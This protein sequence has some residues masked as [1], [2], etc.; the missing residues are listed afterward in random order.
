MS[1]QQ[2]E[3]QLGS[4]TFMIYEDAMNN[5]VMPKLFDLMEKEG[6]SVQEMKSAIE[7][8]CGWDVADWFEEWVNEDD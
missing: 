4:R 2:E 6:L 5:H 7:Y 8:F 3:R 1:T